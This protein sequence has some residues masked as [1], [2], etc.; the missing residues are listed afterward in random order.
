MT[1]NEM[2]QEEMFDENEWKDEGH[3]FSTNYP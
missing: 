3:V 1:I 2:I